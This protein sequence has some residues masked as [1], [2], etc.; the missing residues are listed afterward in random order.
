VLVTDDLLGM[1]ERAPRFVKRY[2]DLAPIIDD[3]VRHYAEE[4]RARR[5]P[6]DA[7]LY[8]AKK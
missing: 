5:F 2:A 6:G 4:V 1:F 3:A 8:Q 7:Q